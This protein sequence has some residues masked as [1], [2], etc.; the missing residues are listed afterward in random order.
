MKCDIVSLLASE[1]G[2]SMYKKIGFKELEK[3]K[4]FTLD[5]YKPSGN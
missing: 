2:F 3:F 1:D 4:V 5:H